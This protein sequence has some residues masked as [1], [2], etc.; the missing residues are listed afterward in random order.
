MS[1]HLKAL[2]KI[3]DIANR[4]NFKFINVFIYT[5]RNEYDEEEQIYENIM[6]NFCKSHDINLLSLRDSFA[7]ELKNEKTLFLKGD[8]HFSDEGAALT[9]KIVA[10]YINTFE[11]P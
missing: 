9:A 10:D 8:V 5:G 7:S 6:S 4:N 2:F 11:N 1:F 3:Q